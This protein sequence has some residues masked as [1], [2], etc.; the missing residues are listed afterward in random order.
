MNAEVP[1]S[2]CGGF[3][4]PTEAIAFKGQP[5]HDSCYLAERFAD[6]DA[7]TSGSGE[8]PDGVPSAVLDAIAARGM[9]VVAHL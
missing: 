4:D 6:P 8:V 3:L 2:A 9:V 7:L 1:C 5:F